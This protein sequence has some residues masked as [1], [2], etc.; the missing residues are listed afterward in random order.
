MLFWRKEKIYGIAEIDI[1]VPDGLKEFFKELPPIF[2]NTIVERQHLS[3]EM[4]D[5]A[6][7]FGLMK[8]GWKC[9][10]ASYFGE[11]IMLSTDYIKWCLD[12]GL[13]VTKCY[14]FLCYNKAKPFMDFLNFVTENRRR[15]D[16]DKSLSVIAETSKLIGNS[17]YGIQLINKAKFENTLF[18]DEKKVDQKVNFFSFLILFY[19]LSF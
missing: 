17:A 19:F 7:E 3:A 14:Q 12:H 1:R 9:L 2:K 8:N 4:Q 10:V 18:V 11:K 5:Y 16:A 13:I 15:G 6:K